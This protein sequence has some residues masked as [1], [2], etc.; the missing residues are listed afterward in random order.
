MGGDMSSDTGEEESHAN[1]E[2]E[3]DS[4]DSAPQQSLEDLA[5]AAVIASS[6]DD[7]ARV[8]SDDSDELNESPLKVKEKTEKKGKRVRDSSE[9]ET[10]PKSKKLS[11]LSMKLSE[12]D[13]S[14]D[15]R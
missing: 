13:S 3:P 4:P 14:E 5:R 8:T 15:E 10:R 6:S 1:R 12:S 9:G 11:L 2:S 7:N